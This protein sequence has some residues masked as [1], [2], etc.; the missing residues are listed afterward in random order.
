MMII[1]G[2]M[3]ASFL[4][5]ARSANGEPAASA[6]IQAPSRASQYYAVI[7]QCANQAYK[8]FGNSLCT[9]VW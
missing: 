1:R 6:R 5:W 2:G 4:M 7:T 3:G 8:L 9:G